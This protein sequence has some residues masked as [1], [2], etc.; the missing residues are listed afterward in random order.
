MGASGEL[1]GGSGELI[2][3]SGELLGAPQEFLEASGELLGAPCVAHGGRGLELGGWTCL[4]PELVQK[5][6]PIIGRA[7]PGA[8]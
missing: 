8:M 1:M 3:D 4:G 7:S 2:G 6:L 5:P